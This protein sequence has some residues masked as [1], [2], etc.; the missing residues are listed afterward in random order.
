M[1]PAVFVPIEKIP[2]T[3]NGKIHRKALPGP[4]IRGIEEY[5]APSSQT[6]EQLLGIYREL[7]EVEKVGIRDGFFALGGN[8][9]KAIKLMAQIHETFNIDVPVAQVFKTPGIKDLASVLVKGRFI[10]NREETVV[11]LN[12][13]KPEKIFAFPPAVGFGIAYAELAGLLEQYSLYAFNYIENGNKKGDQMK[14]YLDAIRDIQ[15]EGPYILLGYSAGAKLCIKLAELLEEAGRQV[16][17]IIILDSYSSGPKLS[18][19]EMENQ[20]VE[21]YQ[22]IEKGIQYLGIRHL[23]QKITNTLK[24]YR[25]YHDN[26]EL[27]KKLGT[28]I[29][30]IQ[31]EDRRGKEEFI[32]WQ[33]FTHDREIVYEGYGLHREMLSPGVIEKNAAVIDRIL[34]ERRK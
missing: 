3:P 2:L 6:E 19:K 18:E 33:A 28:T 14:I 24:K 32:G 23:E 11:L 8:S 13:P 15:P 9:L 7:L 21:F 17:G 20:A 5:E 12:S 29:H 4:E 16:S 26:L 30:L 34:R 27:S 25:Y 10:E 1:V 31:A 22:G